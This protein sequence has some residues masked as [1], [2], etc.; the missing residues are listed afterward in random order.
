IEPVL[1]FGIEEKSVKISLYVSKSTKNSISFLICQSSSL[2][3]ILIGF[4]FLLNLLHGLLISSI[5]CNIAFVLSPLTLSN[6]GVHLGSFHLY[7]PAAWATCLDD[8][9]HIHNNVISDIL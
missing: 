8:G 6:S 1:T 5:F 7:T 9:P 3:S 2:F 4:K